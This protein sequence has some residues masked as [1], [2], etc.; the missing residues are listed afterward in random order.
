MSKGS[1]QK[2]VRATARG[3]KR[4]LNSVRR[5]DKVYQDTL[6]DPLKA[7][8]WARTK[9]NLPRYD[10]TLEHLLK[11]Y[12]KLSPG[13]V[14]KKLDGK[15][16]R[17]P[18]FF[19]LTHYPVESFAFLRKL[20]YALHKADDT[21]LVLDY[22]QCLRIDL[23]ASVCMDVL[24]TR[25]IAHYK[26]TRKLGAD[27]KRIRI[28]DAIMLHSREV[29]KFLQ[30][31]GSG[32]VIQGIN[33]TFPDIISCPLRTRYKSP[34]RKGT[35]EITTTELVQYL[36][37]CLARFD[38]KLNAKDRERFS[39]IIG[40]VL[41]N[42]ED[43]SSLPYNYSIGHFNE[44]NGNGE[45]SGR[46]QC[47]IL[48]FGKTIYER[49]K[50]PNDCKNKDILPEMQRLS[51]RYTE[52][53]WFGVKDAPFEEETLWTLYALQDGVSSVA[54]HRGN[55]TIQFIRDF[56]DL[57]SK[58]SNKRSVMTLI[59]GHTRIQFDGTHH[60]QDKLNDKGDTHTVITFNKAGSLE[61]K[62]DEKFVT[63]ASQYF[64]GTLL[65]ADVY[66]TAD[67]LKPH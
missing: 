60:L 21:H 35:K 64:P 29:R 10:S 34:H 33:A 50:D 14:D 39:D 20:F 44:L 4:F 47:V 62:P 24:L 49:L 19:S 3:Q 15:P 17:V 22:G 46:F 61:E 63:F 6:P 57:R 40:E 9:R 53:S 27:L 52:K 66:V 36:Q 25:F 11:H 65:Y 41:A 2:Q 56:L 54:P 7:T 55:G 18:M 28:I 5:Q 37:A 38:K 48:N 42:A 1:H 30:S 12:R 32:Q 67:H 31:T 51:K 59:S 26:R 43:H 13:I 23:D 45:H 16:L 8:R 58:E